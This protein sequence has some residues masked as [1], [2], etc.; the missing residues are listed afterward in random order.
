MQHKPKTNCGIFRYASFPT[1]VGIFLPF[2]LKFKT[3]N[4]MIM[5]LC[6]FVTRLGTVTQFRYLGLKIK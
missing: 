1:W 3:K 4:L 2:N 5:A 6:S